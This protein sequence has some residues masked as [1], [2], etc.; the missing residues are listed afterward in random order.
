MTATEAVQ[1]SL[2][3]RLGEIAMLQI[4]GSGSGTGVI[5][6]VWCE[7]ELKCEVAAVALTIADMMQAIVTS[8]YSATG[9]N[10]TASM[11][12]FLHAYFNFASS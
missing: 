3:S 12:D 6:C 2:A 1:L 7:H 11:T 8:L 9:L 10:A 4:W 5:R